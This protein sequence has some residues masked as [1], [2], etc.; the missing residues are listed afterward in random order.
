MTFASELAELRDGAV[1]CV[2]PD[3]INGGEIEWQLEVEYQGSSA[4]ALGHAQAGPWPESFSAQ[5]CCKDCWWHSS[6]W[7]KH[8]SATDHK[9]KQSTHADGCRG[10]L[11]IRTVSEHN[12]TLSRLRCTAFTSEA[13]HADALRAAG[14]GKL[15]CTLDHIYTSPERRFWL[16]GCVDGQPPLALARAAESDSTGCI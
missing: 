9:R 8:A 3:D 11:V 6:C 15:H 13:R 1:T 4:D 7:C 2:L 12:D 14:L 10:A 5:H 16:R